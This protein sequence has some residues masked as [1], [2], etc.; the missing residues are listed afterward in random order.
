LA[1]G[2]RCPCGLAAG[3]RCPCGLAA[4][5]QP[6]VGCSLAGAAL[7]LAAPASV[8][9]QATVLAGACRPYGLVTTGRPLCKGPWP[10]LVAP[11][12][13]ALATVDRPLAGG[14]AMASRP[15]RRPGRGWPPILLSLRLLQKRSKNA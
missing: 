3:G 1:A 10:Q 2:E 8:A 12:Q 5:E 7:Q 15:Y 11:L 6:L 4:G 9:L 14:Q 13:G